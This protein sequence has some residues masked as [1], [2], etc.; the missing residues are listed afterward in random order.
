MILNGI[1]DW[2]KTNSG[3]LI[4]TGI[5][6]LIII[7]IILILKFI[8]SRIKLNKHRKAKSLTNFIYSII[9]FVLIIL[10]T[11]F[12]LASWGV[13]TTHGTIILSIIILII[14]FGARRTLQDIFSGMSIVFMN[15]YE[16]GDTIETQG[17]RGKV[18]NIT[19]SKTQLQNKEGHIITIS[20]GQIRKVINY[21][22]LAVSINVQVPIFR[23]ENI[24]NII[25]ELGVLLPQ[26]KE[27]YSQIIEGPNVRGI[28]A[29]E[30][31]EVVL[32]IGA[33]VKIN[34]EALIKRAILKKVLDYSNDLGKKND[35]KC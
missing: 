12:I 33:S 23:K 13:N 29:I 18:I 10:G 24:D 9:V 31:S 26:L 28:E 8:F 25:K 1:T 19:M 20:N 15:L 6:L 27:E 30:E 2:F 21:K 4:I 32:L 34:S 7:T 16:V 14:G 5:T 35:E 11:F 22:N 3:K 17:V